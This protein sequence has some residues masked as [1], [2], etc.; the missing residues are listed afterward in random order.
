[1]VGFPAVLAGALNF[2]SEAV[3]E[4]HATSFARNFVQSRRRRHAAN[5]RSHPFRRAVSAAA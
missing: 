3:T 1:M 2:L 4:F 5:L